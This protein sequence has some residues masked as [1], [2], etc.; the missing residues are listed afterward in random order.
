MWEQ[1]GCLCTAVLLAYHSI[2]DI[3][4]QRI[5]GGSLAL[6]VAVSCGWAIGEGLL[7]IQS[8]EVLGAGLLPGIAA[9]ALAKVTREQMGR[10]DGWELIIMGNGMG[11]ANCLLALGTALLGIFLVSVALLLLGKARRS[12]RIAF[13]PFLGMGAM[14]ALLR[15]LV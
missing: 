15:L 11:L 13:V 9:L 7:G 3:K 2:F 12:T 4:R 5:P 6:G 10:G 14:A 1:I 8:W